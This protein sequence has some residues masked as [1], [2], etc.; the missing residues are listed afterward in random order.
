MSPE[1]QEF[2]QLYERHVNYLLQGNVEA[3]LA[4]MVQE[5]IPDVF[6]GINVPYKVNALKII[7]VRREGDRWVGDTVYD[8]PKGH[9]GL[10]SFW[11]LHDGKW[12]AADLANFPVPDES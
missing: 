5:R 2:R 12:L 9:I 11:D 8:T 7:D 6:K 4:D 1:A 10:R 3:A